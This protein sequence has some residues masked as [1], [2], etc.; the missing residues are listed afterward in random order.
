MVT[1][2]SFS[3]HESMAINSAPKRT[4]FPS[5]SNPKFLPVIRTFVPGTPWL[6]VNPEISGGRLPFPVKASTL[7]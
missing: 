5:G 3:L 4:L 7:L 1:K 6:G 2:I